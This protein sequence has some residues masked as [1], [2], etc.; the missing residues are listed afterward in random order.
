MVLCC[1]SAINTKGGCRACKDARGLACVCCPPGGGSPLPALPPMDLPGLL[2]LLL[3]LLLPCRILCSPSKSFPELDSPL[4]P[5]GPCKAQ[6]AMP[7]NAKGHRLARMSL[8][9]PA[10]QL[11]LPGVGRAGQ[12]AGKG[13]LSSQGQAGWGT[14]EEDGLRPG[15]LARIGSF[16][17]SSW[18]SQSLSALL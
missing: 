10:Q 9:Q 18:I 1:S 17:G 13:W 2:L 14:D 7:C 8:L 15:R 12:G 11:L 3:R 5:P 4:L 6:D 16:L